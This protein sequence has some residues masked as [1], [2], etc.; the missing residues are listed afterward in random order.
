[1]RDAVRDVLQ[2]HR[3]A[4]ARGRDDQAA[5]PLADRDHQV[6]HAGGEVLGLCFERDLLLRIERREVLEEHLLARL[7]RRLEVDR[8]DLDEGEVALAVLGRADLALDG[9]AGVQVEAPDLR[10]RD[11]DVVGAGEI[12]RV[13]RAQEAETVLEHL[14][15]A[16]AEDRF[17]LLRLVLEEGEHEL[18]LAKAVGAFQLVGVRH[19]DELGDGL[20]LEVR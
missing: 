6:E 15:G 20:E 1:M 4:R 18:L 9:I 13:G 14:E 5:L 11:V 12:G 2:Q 10:G 7:F 19:L 8:F 17:A 16:V 3:L